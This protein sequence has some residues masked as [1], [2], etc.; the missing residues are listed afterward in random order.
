LPSFSQGDRFT[1]SPSPLD[2][3][4][5][6]KM[7]GFIR[8]VF[9]FLSDVSDELL[10]GITIAVLLVLIALIWKLVFSSSKKIPKEITSGGT[11]VVQPDGKFRRAAPPDIDWHKGE[12]KLKKLL[13]PRNGDRYA[14]V[15]VG[16]VGRWIVEMLLGRGEREILLLD[17]APP[18]DLDRW[19][20][21]FG[22]NCVTFHRT[23]VTS[24]EQLDAVFGSN[25]V[26]SVFLTMALI[27][28]RERMSFQYELPYKVNVIGTQ[29]VLDVCAKHGVK[30]LIQTSTSNVVLGWD[31][32]KDPLQLLTEEEPYATEPHINHYVPT[33][34]LAEKAVLTADK[35]NGMRTVA[36]RPCSG[37]FGHRDKL[38]TQK[39]ID[40][41][42]TNII[43][44]DARI[45]YVYAENIALG[46]ILADEK[47]RDPKT[48]D[49]VGGEVFNINNNEPIYAWEFYT[50][51][52]HFDSTIAYTV[53][54]VTTLWY[55]AYIV[56]WLQWIRYKTGGKWLLGD[57]EYLTPSTLQAA[58][59]SYVCSGEKAARLLGYSPAYSVD[60]G[61]QKTIFLSKEMGTK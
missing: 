29:N 61:L 20:K 50:T 42:M 12:E 3:L 11:L 27:S 6:S 55:V 41:K 31:G 28:F 19:K 52:I 24:V 26:T 21:E 2:S 36:I 22:E 7:L 15:G 33:K 14:V 16:S 39:M 51:L 4:A 46:H 37:V 44:M 53:L 9:P 18:I 5:T 59:M 30:R 32:P 35:K 23:D 1:T 60:E 25:D 47:L 48:T 8:S 56:E 13:P 54:P 45:D 38:I 57:L 43:F 10:L 40:S 17:I 58:S 49:Q 34:I